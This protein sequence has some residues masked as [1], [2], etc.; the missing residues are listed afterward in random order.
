MLHCTQ[1]KVVNLTQSMNGIGTVLRAG[2]RLSPV[3]MAGES[4]AH[5][6]CASMSYLYQVLP[7]PSVRQ[8]TWLETWH[9]APLP[10]LLQGG[11]RGPL[12]VRPLFPE[13]A[14]LEEGELG[15]GTLNF[16]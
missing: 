6:E 3:F 9:T 7:R 8:P 5:W 4:R 2:V 14:G 12:S 13:A 11:G 15:L 16:P 10:Q 1:L